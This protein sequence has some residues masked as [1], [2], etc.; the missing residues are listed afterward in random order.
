MKLLFFLHPLLL[1]LPL[2]LP[3]PLVPLDH[4]PEFLEVDAQVRTRV[5]VPV[6]AVEEGDLA[7]LIPQYPD[8]ELAGD[9]DE[10]PCGLALGA[11]TKGGRSWS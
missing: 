4:R 11:A 7:V 2:L 1:L 9:V 3:N 6:V 10:L 5:L 8:E